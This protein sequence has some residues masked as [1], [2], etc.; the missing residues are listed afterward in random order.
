MENHTLFPVVQE[1]H[2]ETSSLIT[3]KIMPQKPQRNCMF[4][5]SASVYTSVHKWE[6]RLR[7]NINFFLLFSAEDV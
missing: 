2:T 6:V 1:I 3:L 7:R 4:M 5:N